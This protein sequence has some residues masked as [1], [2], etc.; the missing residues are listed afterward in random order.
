MPLTASADLADVHE[1]V[2]QDAGSWKDLIPVNW[3]SS[4][5]M[6]FEDTDDAE[7][8]AGKNS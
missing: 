5:A 8:G 6:F 7:E 3:K 4:A 1:A 2:R